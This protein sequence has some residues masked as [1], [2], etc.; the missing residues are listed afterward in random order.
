LSYEI[1]PKGLREM[2][3]EVRQQNVRNGWYDKGVTFDTTMANLHAEVSEA[4][5]AWRQWG[6]TD[7]TEPWYDEGQP[8]AS[9]MPKPEGVGSEFA[10]VLIRLLDD[11][12]RFHVDLSAEYARKM[13]YNNTRSYRHGNKRA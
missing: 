1:P 8:D 9:P 10:D 3:E 5:E 11:C 12:E 13:R 2:Q 4:W 7:V 6:L